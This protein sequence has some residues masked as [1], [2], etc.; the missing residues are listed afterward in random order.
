MRASSRNGLACCYGPLSLEWQVGQP[1]G[2]RTAEGRTA[3]HKRQRGTYGS[4][5]LK[6]S[7]SRSRSQSPGRGS[8]LSSSGIRPPPARAAWLRLDGGDGNRWQQPALLPG[9]GR[10]GH[11]AAS[12]GSGSVQ[13]MSHAFHS[14]RPC[15]PTRGASVLDAEVWMARADRTLQGSSGSQAPAGD[16]RHVLPTAVSPS[17]SGNRTEGS[18]SLGRGFRLPVALPRSGEKPL[19]P[20]CRPS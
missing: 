3:L 18:S 13:V 1:P 8:G 7:A 20:P 4:G 9:Q 12:I 16:S 17:P 11:G 6:P 10:V 5:G 19:I 14:C 2:G 15:A